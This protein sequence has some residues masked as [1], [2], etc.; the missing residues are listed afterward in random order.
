MRIENERIIKS[1][2]KELADRDKALVDY[3]NVLAKEI[4]KRSD[5]QDALTQA[6]AE[7]E[8]LI[9][10]HEA[11]QRLIQGDPLFEKAENDKERLN[12][13]WHTIQ[14]DVGPEPIL[15][16]AYTRIESLEVTLAKVE[17]ELAVAKANQEISNAF[18]L[19][20]NRAYEREISRLRDTLAQVV[21][22]GMIDEMVKRCGI[23]KAKWKEWVDAHNLTLQRVASE[24]VS[25][26]RSV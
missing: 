19:G 11:W 10:D 14:Y 16:W 25:P 26:R 15:V 1:C 4:I 8:K 5:L 21:E 18:T 13:F 20:S 3:Q 2:Q 22:A 17:Q 6:L 12:A 9:K 7:K 24:D 23:A